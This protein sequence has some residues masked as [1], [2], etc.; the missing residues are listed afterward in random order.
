M[1]QIPLPLKAR[2]TRKPP[3]LRQQPLPMEPDPLVIQ[4]GTPLPERQVLDAERAHAVTEA[5]IEQVEKNASELYLDMLVDAVRA[6][7]LDRLHLASDD[8]HVRLGGARMRL[9]N[10]SALGA[11]FRIAARLGYIRLQPERKDSERPATHRRPLRIWESC[12]YRGGY[13]DVA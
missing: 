12:I 9:G 6:V 11:A 8:V 5:A 3:R 13:G 7:A 10:P 2:K 4:P 1:E